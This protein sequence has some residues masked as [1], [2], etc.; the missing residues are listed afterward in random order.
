MYFTLTGQPFDLISHLLIT[1][2]LGK[3]STGLVAGHAYTLVAAKQT[4]KGDRLV[5]LRYASLFFLLCGCI[6]TIFMSAEVRIVK[7]SSVQFPI[8]V[9][10][11]FISSCLLSPSHSLVYRNP[12]GSM[13]WTG[14]WSDNSPLWTEEMQVCCFFVCLLFSCLLLSLAH[15]QGSDVCFSVAP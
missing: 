3:D 7:F 12:W 15:F 8:Y 2:T 1:I 14:D 13:E 6:Q 4:S 10:P 9:L 5:K 11:S